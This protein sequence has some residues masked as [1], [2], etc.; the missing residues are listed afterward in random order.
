[1]HLFVFSESTTSDRLIVA[2]VD[3]ISVDEEEMHTLDVKSTAY[4]N[5]AVSWI[6]YI[7]YLSCLWQGIYTD[8]PPSLSPC[9]VPVPQQQ[10]VVTFLSVRVCFSLPLSHIM[11]LLSVSPES[12]SVKCCPLFIP[13]YL[14]KFR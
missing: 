9:L 3:G 4:L 10:S 11:L 13:V 8:I 12:F 14:W 7:I 1:M 2:S 5:G 6:I